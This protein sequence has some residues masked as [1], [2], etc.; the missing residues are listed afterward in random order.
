M[1]RD[2]LLDAAALL[3]PVACAGCGAD[4][5]ALCDACRARL[6]PRPVARRLGDGT[7]VHAGLGYGGVARAVIL[8]FKE[9]SRTGL[10][11]EL[12]PALVAAVASAV[13]GNPGPSAGLELCAVP[14]TRRARRRRGFEPVR[15]VA[16]R[17]G[18]R[19]APVLR[20]ARPHPAQKTLALADRA[21][22]LDG[23]FV[24]RGPLAA[25]RFVL[26]DDVVTTGATLLAVSRALRSAGAE[27]V[28]AAAVAS[29]P[30]F[31]ADAAETPRDPGAGTG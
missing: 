2:A 26:V 20:P 1:L 17:A 7:P 30:R 3:L 10:A 11:R 31:R 9:E 19:L 28:A 5:R 21:A 14:G 16:G 25:R 18:L 29:T 13:A 27:V 12:A 23:V 24:A 15:L 6:A 22:A 8:A 4:D